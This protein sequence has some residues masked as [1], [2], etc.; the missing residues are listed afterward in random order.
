MTA[1]IPLV[2]PV[3]LSGGGLS[4]QTT[5]SRIGSRGLFVRSLLSPKEGAQMALVLSL[6]GSARP[7]QM[8][9]TVGPRPAEAAKDNGF[10]VGFDELSDDARAFLDV[11][12][13]SRGVEGI[14]RPPAP[15]ARAPAPP[16]TRPQASARPEDDRAWPRVPAR[17]RVGWTSSKDFLSAYSKNISRGGVFIATDSPPEL[18]EVVELS[19]ELPDGGPPVKTRAEVVHRVTVEE[20][21][22]SGG[23]AGAGLQFLDASHDFQ[24]RLDACIEALSD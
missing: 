4:M 22:K 19:V 7:L 15:P 1:T 3:R 23:V 5:T 24:E 6:P 20:A 11:L 17:L 12:L 18:R 21:R 2:A 13:R 10:W 14:R 16:D 9:G 8:R